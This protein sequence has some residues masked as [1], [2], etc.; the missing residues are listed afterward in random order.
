ML[1]SIHQVKRLIVAVL[2]SATVL[3]ELMRRGMNVAKLHFAHGTV[4]G[5]REDIRR[6]R[7]VA[8]KLRA[9]LDYWGFMTCE[10]SISGR[11]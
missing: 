1:R 6:I 8:G 5:H 7:F 9:F 3:K 2:L 11:I 4:E 10:P